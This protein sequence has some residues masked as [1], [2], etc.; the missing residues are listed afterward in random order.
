MKGG[1]QQSSMQSAGSLQ[2]SQTGDQR[3]KSSYCWLA[4]ATSH[5]GLL[6]GQCRSPNMAA[7]P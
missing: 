5:D 4:R 3:V 7:Y 1:S 6:I 2:L